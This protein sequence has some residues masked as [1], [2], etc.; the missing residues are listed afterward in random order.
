MPNAND[1]RLFTGVP[2]LIGTQPKR[3]MPIRLGAILVLLALNHVAMASP[4][5]EGIACRSVHLVYPGDNATLF[6]NEVAVRESHPGTYFC[7]CGFNFGYYG[8]QEL[9]SGK[10]LLIFSVWDPGQQDDPNV[11][12]DEQRVKLLHQDKAV[13]VG[14]FGN[15]GTGGQSFYDF[16]W[17]PNET[18]RFCVKAT[19]DAAQ[20]RT[21]FAAYFYEPEQ[22]AW[23]HLVTFDRPT[24]DEQ[25]RGYYSFVEDFRRNRISATLT[26]TADFG[27]GWI[28]TP[29]QQ[30]HPLTTARFTGDGN[31]VL[32]I[33]AGIRTPA[34]RFFLSTGGEITNDHTKL[35]A[36]MTLDAEHAADPPQ[37]L[38]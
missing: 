29:D 3:K 27:N 10:K 30:W 14:R 6:Y 4:E 31:P 35:N 34:N 19:V 21:A 38:P 8:L 1:L 13:R 7:V 15:E 16:D 32:N 37:D 26:R 33:D 23:K 11:V 12:K 18:Y 2:S 24:K 36:T 5:L 22:Q 20:H 25:L 28:Q 9:A 17:K